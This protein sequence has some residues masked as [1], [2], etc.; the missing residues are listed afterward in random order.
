MA[1]AHLRLRPP[2]SAV[3][4][5]A[6]SVHSD[7]PSTTAQ[8]LPL[9]ST[10]DATRTPAPAHQRTQPDRGM[11]AADRDAV[12]R[13]EQ[14][15]PA[16]QPLSST[17][18]TGVRLAASVTISLLFCFVVTAAPSLSSIS[19]CLPAACSRI[20]TVALTAAFLFVIA[21]RRCPPA[22][23]VVHRSSRTCDLGCLLRV[24]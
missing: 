19:R 16:P 2:A 8:Q 15:R 24:W 22:S 20:S 18:D 6:S 4:H 13:A 21:L 11:S 1:T 23:H 5:A 10:A 7:A 12:D 14:R 3:A 9:H 17:A